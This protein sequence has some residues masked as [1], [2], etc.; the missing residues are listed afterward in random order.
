MNDGVLTI[1]TRKLKRF[2]S[3]SKGCRDV[4]IYQCTF[5][6]ETSQQINGCFCLLIVCKGCYKWVFLW[7]K[8][9]R[10]VT[11]SVRHH[12]NK[13]CR[14]QRDKATTELNNAQNTLSRL[15]GIFSAAN[16]ELH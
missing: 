13:A 14:K 6:P 5:L 4:E 11:D 16:S 1:I 2:I 7:N 9:C 3:K 12:N 8:F 15:S 10:K